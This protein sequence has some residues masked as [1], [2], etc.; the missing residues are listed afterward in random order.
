MMEGIR[1]KENNG[2]HCEGCNDRLWLNCVSR[3]LCRKALRQWPAKPRARTSCWHLATYLHPQQAAT[4]FSPQVEKEQRGMFNWPHRRAQT[5]TRTPLYRHAPLCCT[6]ESYGILRL[7][8]GTCWLFARARGTA[9]PSAGPISRLALNKWYIHAF[10]LLFQRRVN[11][12][13]ILN[14]LKKIL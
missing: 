1:K 10:T 8:S 11:F 14:Y 7:I 4:A 13:L 3:L 9:R 2:R 5:E 12:I 6:K